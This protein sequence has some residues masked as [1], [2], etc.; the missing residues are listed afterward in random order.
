[1]IRTALVGLAL[2][3]AVKAIEWRYCP[4]V[5]PGTLPGERPVEISPDPKPPK[6]G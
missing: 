5:M 4:P 3:F 6:K 2:F 1:M